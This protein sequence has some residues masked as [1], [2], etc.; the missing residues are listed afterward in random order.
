MI[1]R[2]ATVEDAQCLKAW[3]EDGRLMGPVGFPK[4]LV[5]DLDL[6]K[7]KLD[8]PKPGAQLFMIEYDGAV[9]GEV[10]YHD[11]TDQECCMG[12]KIALD[13][14]GQGLGK[15]AAKLFADYLFA[16]YP[17]E[18]IVMDPMADNV[19]AIHVYES[20]GFQREKLIENIWIDPEGQS[21]DALVMRL[22]RQDESK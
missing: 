3:Y 11:M 5:T 15:K 20:I 19:R 2:P 6:L 8:H 14:Q 7:H 16:L 18:S 17:I 21:R 4:G 13:Y 10:N 12:I 1:F 22:R 9:I